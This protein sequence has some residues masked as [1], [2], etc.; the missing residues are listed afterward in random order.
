MLT[1]LGRNALAS[2]ALP[3][4]NG[5]VLRSMTT[6]AQS[7]SRWIARR[8][9]LRALAELDDH[10]L[11]DIGLAREDVRRACS[12][13]FWMRSHEPVAASLSRPPRAT[14]WME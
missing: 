14:S 2:P 5:A 9:Q 11:R 10:L 6:A 3:R 13:S 8:R 7:V 4:P 1:M 12:Q